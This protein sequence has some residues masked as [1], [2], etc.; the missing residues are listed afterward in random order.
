MVRDNG[1]VGNDES[2]VVG[3]AVRGYGGYGVMVVMVV[4]VAWG[5]KSC[6]GFESLYY[7]NNTLGYCYSLITRM[8]NIMC[9]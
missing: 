4:M 9:R 1:E 3:D 5:N 2:L 7:W 6:V 8:M